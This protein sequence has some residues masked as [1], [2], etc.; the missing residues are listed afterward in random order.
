MIKYNKNDV[1]KTKYF[2]YQYND[3]NLHSDNL[4]Y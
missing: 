3:T 1:Y 4:R 2:M